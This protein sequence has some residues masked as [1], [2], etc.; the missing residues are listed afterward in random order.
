MN[1]LAA[2]KP[3]VG[4]RR[5]RKK[6][7]QKQEIYQAATALFMAKGYENT[8]IDMIADMADIGRA[9]FFNYYPTK[10]DILH[11]IADGAVEHAKRVFDKEFGEGSG[12]VV[13]KIKRSFTRFAKIVERNPEYYQTVFIDVMRTQTG[14]VDAKNVSR[15]NLID[16]LA[17][18]LKAE[19]KKGEIDPSLNPDQLSEMLTGIY[20]YTILNCGVRD[21]SY[22]LVERITKA[23]EIF[24][25][26]C[27]PPVVKTKP[28][29]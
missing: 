29:A 4:S 6:R 22:S 3:T 28:D 7:A 14:F 2:G 27:A 19:Q 21:F 9:T 17:D 13:E 24:V 18:H 20:N 16:V 12:P 23:A 15:S 26:G 10:A 25:Q 11:E 5:E 8:T 1:A